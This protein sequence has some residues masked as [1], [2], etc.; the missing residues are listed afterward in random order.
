M[1]IHGILFLIKKGSLSGPNNYRSL[2][3]EDPILKVL[4]TALTSRLSDFAERNSLL[5]EFQ[6]GFRK[7]LSATSAVSLVR[8]CIE[9]AFRKKK[10]IYACFVDYKKAFD[11]TNRQKLTSKLQ[12]MGVPTQLCK[13]IFDILAGLRLRVR[14]NGAISPE[15]A[16]FNGVPQGDPLSPLLYSLYTADLP[17]FLNHRGVE[18]G[19]KDLT[20]KYLLY[21]D[22]L[23]LLS[24]SSQDLQLSINSLSRYVDRTELIVNVAK[25]KCMVFHMGFCPEF[26]CHFKGKRLETCKS[27]NY[28][29]VLL[30]T[31]LSS[32]QHLQHILSKC[33]QRIGFLFAKLPLKNIPL[34]VALSIFDTYVLSIITYALSLWFPKA[35]L[36]SN[37]RE[38]LDALFTKFLKRYLGVPYPTYNALVHFVT[39]TIPLCR[40]LETK[41]EKS[42]YRI[43]YPP[44]MDGVQ[45][46]VPNLECFQYS[47]VEHIPSFFWMSPVINFPLPNNQDV[48]RALLYDS[49]DLHH[50]KMCAEIKHH[51]PSALCVCIHCGYSVERYHFRR[52]P[53]VMF[54]TPCG[55]LK[56]LMANAPN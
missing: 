11:I 29:G 55:R 32:G 52:C 50:R 51:Q 40:T 36:D 49:F 41:V 37:K 4:M 31:Q 24:H 13:L 17:D 43:S 28:L 33:K 21:A 44:C 9:N 3:I 34:P 54:R 8:E 38:K 7:S 14:S 5:P 22:D 10:R 39:G 16:T 19:Q 35:M 20:I 2:A 26:S 25:T 30:T 12:H 53:A 1:T 47:V 15:F 23:L 46:P 27:F 6:F 48:R 45:F 56:F 18:L 42:F